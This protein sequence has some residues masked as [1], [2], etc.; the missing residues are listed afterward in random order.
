MKTT[1]KTAAKI[2]LFSSIITIFGG[3]VGLGIFFKNT[4]VFNL[5]QHNPYGT[6]IS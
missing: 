5:N 3:V 1:Q 4:S 2:G 6:I